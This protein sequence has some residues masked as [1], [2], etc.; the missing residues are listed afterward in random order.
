MLVARLTVECQVSQLSLFTNV[1][2]MSLHILRSHPAPCWQNINLCQYRLSQITF[3][4]EYL[5]L[6]ASWLFL[7]FTRTNM[8]SSTSFPGSFPWLGKR[9]WE[10]GWGSISAA[11]SCLVYFRTTKLF[12]TSHRIGWENDIQTMVTMNPN[13]KTIELRAN[14][15]Q[16]N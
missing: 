11:L 14:K 8:T 5:P 2:L 10:R 6:T 7:I 13:P 4:A 16:W 1:L 12:G 15:I 9:P 3:C